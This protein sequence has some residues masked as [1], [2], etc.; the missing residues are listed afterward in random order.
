MDI[1][2]LTPTI[3]SLMGISPPDTSIKTIQTDLIRKLEEMGI[4]KI[5]KCLVYCPDAIG[6]VLYNKFPQ[7]FTEMEKVI[8]WK[9]NLSSIY[10]PKTPVCFASMF[11]GALPEV[12][13][14]KK[15]ERFILSVDTIFDALVMGNKKV[16]IVA[17]KDSSIDLI[18][19]NRKIDYYS[20]K[21]DEEVI[22]RVSN[23]LINSDYDFILAYNQEYDDMLH[24][25]EPYSIE[26]L[27]ALKRHNENY[28]Y[29][30]NLV[31]EHWKNYNRLMVYAPDHG[32]H[33]D[34]TIGK[35]GH[36]YNI[37][38]DMEIVHYYSFFNG[39]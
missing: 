14:I 2:T 18:F 29:L 20:E 17:V 37:P 19:R 6:L 8:N 15:Y 7:Y 3:C 28:I 34:E 32:G 38:E 36:G 35:G 30:L 16:T 4:N 21:Y 39:K 10:P 9:T 13:G 22:E 25:T 11:T 27:E 26:C 31:N 12:H 23:L 24:K 5:E 33:F 1:R